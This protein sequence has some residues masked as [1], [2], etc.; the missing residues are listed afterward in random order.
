MQDCVT[1]Q[2]HTHST[3]EVRET[4]GRKGPKIGIFSTHQ[5]RT[6]DNLDKA[7][8]FREEEGRRYRTQYFS[9]KKEGD[10]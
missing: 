8:F 7:V 2:H 3:N 4:K 10:P 6:I 9:L 1:D 5:T